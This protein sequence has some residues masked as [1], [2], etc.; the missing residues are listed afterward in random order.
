MLQNYLKIAL[1]NLWKQRSY[2]FINLAGM[3][4]GMACCFLLLIYVNHERHYD[5][6]HPKGDRLYRVNY[7][8]NFSGSTFELVRIPAPIGPAMK[9]YF[10]QIE[11]VARLYPRS[12]S[13]REVNTNKQFEIERA[14]FADSTLQDVF[15]M[16][17]IKGD[18]ATALDRPF[19]LVLTDKTALMLFGEKDAMG[20]QVL[21]ANEGPFT[22]TGVV[23]AFPDNAHIHFDLFAPYGNMVDVEPVHARED[24]RRVLTTNWIASHSHTYV[25]LKENAEAQAVDG[26]F[27]AF[28][29]RFGMKE[30]IKK[31]AFTLF[32]VPDIHL[33]STADGETEPAAN[34]AYLRLFLVIGFLILLIA[35]IN[36][37]NLSTATYLSRLKEVGV[38]KVLG[39]G[40]QSLIGQFLGETLM[41]SLLAFLLALML[42]DLLLPHLG[43]LMETELTYNLLTDLNLTVVFVLTFL[44]AGVLAGS[45]PAFFASQFRPV[46]IF[47]S[48]LGKDKSGRHWLRKSL[49]TTQFAVGIAL[50]SGT[51]IILAQLNYWKK[52]PLGFHH[53]QVISVPL[54]SSNM[55]NSFAP[56]DS[57]LRSKMNAF[58]ERL[59][60]NPDIAAVT[61]SNSLPG[62]SAIRHP[63]TTEEVPIEENVFLPCL[64]VDYDF[65]ETFGLE[66][67]AGRDFGKE[68]GTDHTDGF[69]VNEMAVKTLHW[70]TPEN[71]IGK[72]IKRGGKQGKVVGVVK[73]F[74][75]S[76]LQ[77]AMEPLVMEVAVGMFNTFSIRLKGGNVP[78]TIK[79]LET[80]WL[81]FFPEKAFQYNFLEDSLA[82]NYRQEMKLAGLGGHFAGVAIF[83]SCFGLFGLISL[84]VQQ[85]AKEIGI[86]KV[87]GASVTGIVGLLSREFLSLILLSL[88]IAV[89]AAWYVM[90]KWMEDY[91]YRIELSW[92]HF[93]FAGAVTIL[94]AFLTMCFQSL[95]AAL[96]NPV[97][98]LR[99]E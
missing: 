1:R 3:S 90:G 69:I 9:D 4:V 51:F 73:N 19:S 88:V 5:E 63:I 7:Q 15:E 36:F 96:A 76:G 32:P 62:L 91:A 77:N 11:Q 49:I 59:L 66:L 85:R 25:L 18:P 55:N 95:R 8:A 71:A 10:P 45:Y 61:L 46:E 94:V 34:P 26:A 52:Q 80:V 35:C 29:E 74:H 37:I 82:N 48:K 17:Y 44:L 53:E 57:T 84:S 83:L 38:R 16:E 13:V 68:F 81:D 79:F 65:S 41:L 20:R 50:I 12:I 40:R 14:M 67:V 27:P 58:E 30:F 97:K 22:V 78:E 60:Q 39:A 64:S 75:T 47:Q 6:F 72:M 24:V 23:R 56:G 43:R 21:L 28:L 70:D 99:S 33:K 87:L 31:Q 92:W 98:S 54:F 42:V 89:P 93:A 86:R 2:T